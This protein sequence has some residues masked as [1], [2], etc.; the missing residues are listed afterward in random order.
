M[1]YHKAII[2]NNDFRAIEV[3]NLY[4]YYIIQ[5]LFYLNLKKYGSLLISV[6]LCCRSNY[7]YSEYVTK[8][9]V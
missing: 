2:I 9:A 5:F 6:V 1:P 3:F 7:Y 8:S 4:I